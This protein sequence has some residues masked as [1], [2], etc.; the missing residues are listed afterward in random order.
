MLPSGK[1]VVM[2]KAENVM[3]TVENVRKNI[4]ATEVLWHCLVDEVN[5]NA[6]R[7]QPNLTH[8]LVD[9]RY[10]D[11]KLM[12]RYRCNE[13]GF[14][15]SPVALKLKPVVVVDDEPDDMV[16]TSVIQCNLGARHWET[17]ELW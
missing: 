15:S 12:D 8:Q 17:R 5:C 7:V 11:P 4:I 10:I 14:S 13:G 2:K 16:E 1:L 9:Q 6:G 3:K